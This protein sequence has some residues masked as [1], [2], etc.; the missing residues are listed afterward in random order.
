MLRL[1]SVLLILV[2]T[3]VDLSA[4]ILGAHGRAQRSSFHSFFETAFNLV[5]E[6]V[7]ETKKTQ[8]LRSQ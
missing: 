4:K 3:S 2:I 8:V 5:H 1:E 6:V 7:R